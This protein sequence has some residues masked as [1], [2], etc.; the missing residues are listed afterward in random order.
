MMMMMMMMMIGVERVQHFRYRT[1]N[2]SKYLY[3]STFTMTFT[4]KTQ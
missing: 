1:V 4:G 2:K 3:D